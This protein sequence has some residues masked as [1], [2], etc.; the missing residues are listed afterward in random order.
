MQFERTLQADAERL[1]AALP[2]GRALQEDLAQEALLGSRQGDRLV[3]IAALD[4]LIV[5]VRADLSDGDMDRIASGQL[6][7]LIDKIR[8]PGIRSA[9]G[10]ELRNIAAVEEGRD[11]AGRDSEPAERYRDL[12]EAHDRSA[13]RVRE[14]RNFERSDRDLE[15]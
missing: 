4:K 12:M 9:V 14:P 3:D 2:V 10:S 7:P 15:L 6:D 13:E 5:E 1:A 8:D 11:P